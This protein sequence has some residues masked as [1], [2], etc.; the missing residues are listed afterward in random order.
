[1]PQDNE[2]KPFVAIPNVDTTTKDD[3][4]KI[5]GPIISTHPENEDRK[6]IKTSPLRSFGRFLLGVLYF[7]IPIIGW[8][9][10]ARS[11]KR[12]KAGEISMVQGLNGKAELIEEGFYFRPVPFDRFSQSCSKGE[13]FI[14][15]GPL[16]RVRIRE[17]ELG[18]KGKSN[19]QYEELQPGIHTIDTSKSETFDAQ[20]GIQNVN[21]NDFVLGN[22]RYIT[23]RDGFLGESYK[24]GEYLRLEPGRHKLSPG[25]VFQKEVSMQDDVVDLGAEKIITVK[26]GQV[27]VI[28]TNKGVITKGPGRHE[29]KQSERHTFISIITTSPQGV[30]LPSLTVMCTDQI[31][32]KAESMLIVEVTEPLLTVGLGYK[33]IIEDL[34]KLA[35]ATLRRILSRFSSSD[36][37]PTLHTDEEHD[38]VK[39]TAK[40][41]QVHDNFVY[42]LNNAS[43]KWGLK[44]S[45]LQIIQ[46]LPADEGYH[47]TIRNLGTQQSSASAQKRT[48]ETEA[49]IAKIRAEA[50]LSRVVAAQIE[51]KE[52][53]VR[54]DTDAK[55]KQVHAE[56]DAKR[57]VTLADAKAQAIELTAKAEASR[58]RQLTLAS[59]YS[60]PVAQ[61]VMILEAQAKILA[62][63]PNPVFIQPELG[64]TSQWSKAADGKL[65]FFTT[66][67]DTS[68]T[69]VDALALETMSGRA[70]VSASTN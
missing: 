64:N 32:M 31:E 61:Q 26:E 2:N 60:T 33:A 40:L 3:Q 9:A 27:A 53:L 56:A 5:T 24:K 21:N 34:T 37:S 42:E 68:S 58:I 25:H 41:T 52:A 16:K 66:K 57:E 36:I 59:Q 14:D 65:T 17:G 28:K 29:I 46:I 45:D 6:A 48:A 63:V 22:N 8:I 62:N 19:G 50:E 30:T 13:R 54:A 44:V 1:M 69:L 12:V 7:A 35:E 23:I 47:Q 11:F 4:K 70:K 43:A 55:S 49:E 51:Q 20:T 39:R 18:V 67:K 38:S 10:L 15:F